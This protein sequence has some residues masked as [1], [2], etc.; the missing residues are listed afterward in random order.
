MP[1]DTPKTQVIS[2]Q[3]HSDVNAM[4]L[5]DLSAYSDISGAG[6]RVRAQGG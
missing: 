2:E 6:R 3:L 4:D 5:F 1:R